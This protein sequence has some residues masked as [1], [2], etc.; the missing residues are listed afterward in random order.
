MIATFPR[1]GQRRRGGVRRVEVHGFRY[2]LIYMVRPD[3]IFI[4]A[5]A[6]YSRRR[7]YWRHRLKT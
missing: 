5:V 7:G 4:I 2:G 6:H 1:I 3:S